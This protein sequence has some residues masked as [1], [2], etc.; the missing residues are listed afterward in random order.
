[1]NAFALP[2]STA[3]PYGPWSRSDLGAPTEKVY[4]AA[5]S[6]R[7]RVVPLGAQTVHRA[8]STTAVTS[9]VEWL[10]GPS[11]V[12]RARVSPDRTP[13]GVLS[14]EL[15]SYLLLPHGW[16]GYGGK[17]ASL[18]A[19]V[20]AFGFL[21]LKPADIPYPYPQLSSDGEVG[22]YWRTEQLYAEAGFYGDGLY[23]CYSVYMPSADETEEY[24]DDDLEID[25][26]WPDHL[27][28]ML[29][30]DLP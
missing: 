28:L 12:R 24:G 3:V 30:K 27:L 22:V 2:L 10:R 13:Y 8:R 16:D 6:R 1:M 14:R 29:G 25:S 20:D 9:L 18:D 15:F 5:G 23:S 7:A 4:K 26:G 11:H 19:V 21:N 17:P